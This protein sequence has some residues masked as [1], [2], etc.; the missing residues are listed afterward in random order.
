MA[1]LWWLS[2]VDEKSG[3][4]N[5]AVAVEA[6]SFIEACIISRVLKI[7]PGGQVAGVPIPPECLHMVPETH[8]NRLLN[9]AEAESIK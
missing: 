5:G 3:N 8:R 1:S 9:K 4:F 7:S 6:G 2:Y